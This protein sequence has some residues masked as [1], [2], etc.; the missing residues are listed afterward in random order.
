MTTH[1]AS[2]FTDE[3]PP[4]APRPSAEQIRALA[5][6]GG[7]T[8]R[9]PRPPTPQKAGPWRY[10]TGRTAQF[11]VKASQATIDRCEA[12]ARRLE[13]PKAEIIE[14]ALAALEREL[15]QPET[16]GPE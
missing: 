7:F 11:N 6:G 10:R 2:I 1:R 16:A 12:L 9:E 5:E 4:A 13:R 8:S 14:R 3:E 15:A